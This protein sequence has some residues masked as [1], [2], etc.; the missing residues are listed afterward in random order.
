[1]THFSFYAFL[2][3]L[4]TTVFPPP[5][6]D[7]CD[8]LSSYPQSSSLSSCLV[9]NVSDVPSLI[10]E[11]GGAYTVNPT[12]PSRNNTKV[13]VLWITCNINYEYKRETTEITLQRPDVA[14][15]TIQC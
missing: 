12:S 1:M 4:V 15:V 9:V 10:T 5:N 7:G 14:S 6:A 11:L 13:L 2:V 8:V 3:I